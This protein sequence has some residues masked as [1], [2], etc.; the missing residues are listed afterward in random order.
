[1]LAFSRQQVLLWVSHPFC[2]GQ[3]ERVYLSVT[4]NG[5][6]TLPRGGLLASLRNVLSRDEFF[7]GFGA[8]P[9]PMDRLNPSSAIAGSQACWLF[10]A[11]RFCYG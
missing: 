6:M 8:T 7:A 9:A 5:L 10:P 4:S 2:Y 3:V 1:V 11:S